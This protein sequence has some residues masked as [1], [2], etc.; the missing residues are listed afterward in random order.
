MKRCVGEDVAVPDELE[1]GDQLIERRGGLG[2]LVHFT[3]T[4]VVRANLG[5]HQQDVS[6]GY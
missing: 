1:G 5:L 6:S 3:Y 2:S 4:P